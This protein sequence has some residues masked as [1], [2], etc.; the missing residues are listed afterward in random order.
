M[1]VINPEGLPDSGK[2]TTVISSASESFSDAGKERKAHTSETM[3][4]C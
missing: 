2:V 1:W 3:Q 4:R